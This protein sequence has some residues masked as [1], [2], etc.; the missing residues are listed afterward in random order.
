[1][2]DFRTQNRVK[3]GKPSQPH[4]APTPPPPRLGIFLRLGMELKD[5]TPPSPYKNIKTISQPQLK[6]ES[7]PCW[8]A[9]P[10]FTR[11]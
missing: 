3:L 5:Q 2:G 7:P 11:F 8:D 10:S 6:F 1:M 9:F 4:Q